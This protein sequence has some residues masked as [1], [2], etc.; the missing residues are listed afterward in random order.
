MNKYILI[1]ALLLMSVL[2]HAQISNCPSLQVPDHTPM[3][4]STCAAIDKMMYRVTTKENKKNYTPQYPPELNNLENK[5]VELPGYLVPLTSG[6][7]HKT[8]LLSVLPVT[9]CQFCGTN[10]IPPMVEIFMKKGAVKFTE[11][12]IKIKGKMKFN[13]EPLQG[14]AEI[15]IFDAELIN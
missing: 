2:S 6:R 10:G 5:I 1:I 7:N 12:P 4:N 9:Q 11:D 15:Q 13:P 3:R 14:N 8:F